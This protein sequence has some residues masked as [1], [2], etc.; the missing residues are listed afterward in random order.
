MFNEEIM[1]EEVEQ[2]GKVG[3]RFAPDFGEMWQRGG[4]GGGWTPDMPQ[5]SAAV[6]NALFHRHHRECKH[7]FIHFTYKLPRVPPAP[8]I[9]IFLY[10]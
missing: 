7:G 8:Q 1:R 2:V 6:E 3:E 9:W 4:G 10:M 5:Q